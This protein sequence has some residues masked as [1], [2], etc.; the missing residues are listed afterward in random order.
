[1]EIDLDV[2]INLISRVNS[3]L[4]YYEKSFISAK[5]TPDIERK[6][7]ESF[8]EYIEIRFNYEAFK[9]PELKQAVEETE[10][11]LFSIVE[12]EEPNL[13]KRRFKMA[14][15][16]LLDDNLL[17]ESCENLKNEIKQIRTALGGNVI[18]FNCLKKKIKINIENE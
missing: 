11:R 12:L 13:T 15:I 14:K 3:T 7:C 18:C 16:R 10:G 8:E 17:P 4:S 9:I 6:R 2:I 1:M 5:R